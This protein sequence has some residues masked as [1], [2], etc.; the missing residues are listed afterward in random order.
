[1]QGIAGRS[2][3][4]R[5]VGL[6]P[7]LSGTNIK[8]DLVGAVSSQR[9]HP[10]KPSKPPKPAKGRPLSSPAQPPI[11]AGGDSKP[12]SHSAS[13]IDAGFDDGFGAAFDG[14][15]DDGDKASPSA[16]PF[17]SF[18]NAGM[19]GDGSDAFSEFEDWK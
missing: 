12:R 14:F 9:P 11:V 3:T 10:P 1:M 19:S 7:Y 8:L 6:P 4:L 15:G 2:A 13:S 18:G 16:D 17:A 5:A